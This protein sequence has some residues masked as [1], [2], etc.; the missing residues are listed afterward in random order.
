MSRQPYTACATL[1]PELRTPSA[2]DVPHTAPAAF[3]LPPAIR[4]AAFRF[5]RTASGPEMARTISEIRALGMVVSP[6]WA[7]WAVWK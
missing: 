2:G 3:I 5:K 1:L 7:G 4:V 6:V